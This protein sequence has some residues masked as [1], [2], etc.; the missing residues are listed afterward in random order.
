MTASDHTAPAGAVGA[1]GDADGQVVFEARGLSKRYGPVEACRDVSLQVARGE[2]LAI[3][4]DNGAGKSTVAKILTGALKPDSGELFLFGKPVSF[5][6]PLEARLAGVEAVYQELALAPNLDVVENLFLGREMVR[7][8][9][10]LP[11]LRRLADREMTELAR[12]QLRDLQIR[13]PRLRGVPVGRMS[14]GQRQTIAIARAIFW[15]SQVLVMDEPTAALGVKEAGAVL[16]LV[17][18]AVARGIAVVMISHVMSHVVDLA[19]HV[20][21]MRHGVKVDDLRRGEFD[22]ERLVRSIVGA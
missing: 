20:V 3:V 19:D 22:T 16:G 14:G 9:F 4:G 18:E 13:I 6:D 1:L 17:R 15:A 5:T 10:H 11:F 12:R 21:V 7:P 2:L 8:A